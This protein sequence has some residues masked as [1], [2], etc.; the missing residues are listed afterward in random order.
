MAEMT[1]SDYRREVRMFRGELT[2]TAAPGGRR[3]LK[4][5]GFQWYKVK[6]EDGLSLY[7]D[8]SNLYLK[9]FRNATNCYKFYS[10]PD[11]QSRGGA[12]INAVQLAF[13]ESYN[14][15]GP[16]QGIG[17][18]QDSPCTITLGNLN[19]ALSTMASAAFGAKN[20]D[21]QRLAIAR[22]VV[23]LV[24]ASRFVDVEDHIVAGTQITDRSWVNHVDQSKLFI[25]PPA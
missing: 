7:I 3:T 23:G 24:E 5:A 19:N 22:C 21:E 4:G 6:A 15:N 14:G 10:L 12:V 20:T 1:A 25:T 17:L 18:P 11:P 2:N 9:A 13:L 8:L 16:R